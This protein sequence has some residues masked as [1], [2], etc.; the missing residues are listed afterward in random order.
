MFAENLILLI[1]I[2]PLFIMGLG[3]HAFNIKGAIAG[4]IVGSLIIVGGGWLYL[5]M[6]FLFLGFSYISTLAGFQRKE[7]KNLQE[8]IRGERGAKNV[9][10]AGMLPAAVSLLTFWNV[11]PELIFFIYIITLGVILSDTAASE[12]GALDENTYLILTLKPIETGTNGGIS[13]LGTSVSL[14]F[15]I[16]FSIV[17]FLLFGI[18]MSISLV[19]LVELS[20]LS[21]SIAFLGSVFDSILG[22]T[23]ENR[24]ILGKYSVNFIAAA[25]GLIIGFLVYLQ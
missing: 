22:E 18:T 24:G 12:I 1:D 10:A 6:L 5:L 2:P 8:G 23:L 25:F 9:L 13:F 19:T 4:A 11:R 14:V 21:G 3:L 15:P 17:G 7:R 20:L 16:L